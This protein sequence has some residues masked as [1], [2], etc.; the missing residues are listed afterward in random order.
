M[1]MVMWKLT[2]QCCTII[3]WGPITRTILYEKLRILIHNEKEDLLKDSM[4]NCTEDLTAD[5]NEP[6]NIN[7]AWNGK[8]SAEWKKGTESQYKSVSHSVT[9]RT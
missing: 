4:M 3:Y 8:N 6:S 7:E 9:L 5:I 2:F 1:M